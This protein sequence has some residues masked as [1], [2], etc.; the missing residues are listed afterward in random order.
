M[1]FFIWVTVWLGP[2]RLC[3]LQTLNL[4]GNWQRWQAE[5]ADWLVVCSM[6]ALN[7]LRY[8]RRAQSGPVGSCS[9]PSIGQMTR[10]SVISTYSIIALIQPRYTECSVDDIATSRALWHNHELTHK[11]TCKMNRSHHS[12]EIVGVRVLWIRSAEWTSPIS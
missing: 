5:L 10:P 8:L 11:R 4:G 1:R 3:P 6:D 2:S 12:H 9:I 7:G